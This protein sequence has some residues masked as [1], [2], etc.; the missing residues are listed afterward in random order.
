MACGLEKLADLPDFVGRILEERTIDC[1]LELQK[2]SVPLGLVAMVYEA[3]P[4]VTADAAGICIRTGNACILR[5]GSWRNDLAWRSPTCCPTP[6]R[7][8]ASRERP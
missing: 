3:R 2:V 5:G 6:W 4:N 7:P 8:A 1:G